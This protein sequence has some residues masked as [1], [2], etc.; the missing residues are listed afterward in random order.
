MYDALN[1]VLDPLASTPARSVVQTG[2]VHRVTVDG[3]LCVAVDLELYVPGHPYAAEISARCREAVITRAAAWASD[4]A[5]N[6][7]RRRQPRAVA[8][9]NALQNVA[10][11]VAVSSCKGGVGK[12]TVAVNLA[13]TLARRGLRV[14]LLDADIYGPSLP[15]LVQPLDLTVRRSAVNPKWV[16]PLECSD[17]LKVMSFGYVNPRSGAPGAGGKGP[18]VMR[19][20]I[21]TRVI[22][23][24]VAATEWG[25]LDYLL[26]DMPPGTGD[27]QITLTQAAAI[28][29]AVI[30]TTPHTLSLAD[31]AKGVAMF[32]DI[33]VPTLAV[34]ENM[35]FF[36][37]D[38]GQRYYPFGRGGRDQLLRALADA[39]SQEMAPLPMATPASSNR[40]LRARLEIC[41]LHCLPLS[42]E[43]AG[44]QQQGPAVLRSSP[45]SPLAQVY[46]ALAD[47]VILEI[48][49]LQ[50][51]AQTAPTLTYIESRHIVVVRYFTASQAT[52][53]AVPAL[54]LRVR[55]PQTGQLLPDHARRRADPAL[56]AA[57]PVH[58][59]FKGNYGV[60]VNWSDGHHADIFP[61]DVLKHI[62]E[63]MKSA[64]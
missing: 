23:Q 17:G 47:D 24:L 54:E 22:T 51:D 55:N 46:A 40:G 5:V 6:V 30:V 62:G 52:E 44:G 14:G 29:G 33:K 12:S 4:V 3:S 1:T 21:A 32:D 10:H 63:E 43:A 19:G 41:P 48:A 64:L 13:C 15:L 49:R 20:P 50:M 60:A 34:V 18:A 28:T 2:L 27:I 16:Q 26:V 8:D 59:D 7:L 38:R 45:G 53:F 9:G 61:F 11:V 58:F 56:R 42:A 25:D 31:A 35:S 57:R 39:A 37:C 36:D